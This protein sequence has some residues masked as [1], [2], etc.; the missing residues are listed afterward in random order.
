MPVAAARESDSS[1]Q[2]VGSAPQQVGRASGVEEVT[3]AR[4]T[5]CTR[6]VQLCGRPPKSQ[7]TTVGGG[8]LPPP[9]YTKGHWTRTD[10]PQRVRLRAASIGAGAAEGVERGNSWHLQDW[11]C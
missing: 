10:T 11:I 2:L 6:A 7:C 9:P 4:L 3:E 1:S 5:T 8:G